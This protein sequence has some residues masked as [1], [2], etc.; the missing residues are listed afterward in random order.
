ME[1]ILSAIGITRPYFK[2]FK[3]KAMLLAETTA[4]KEFIE[5][6]ER[7]H[8]E[9]SML[10]TMDSISKCCADADWRIMRKTG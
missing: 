7:S 6:L 5:E 1:L 3:C 4:D 8:L 2:C 9:L 10:Q